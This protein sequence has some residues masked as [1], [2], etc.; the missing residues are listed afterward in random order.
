MSHRDPLLR[1]GLIGTGRIS[2]IYLRTCAKF[3]EVQVVACGSLNMDEARAKAAEH[4]IPRVATPDD[5]LADPDIDCILNLTIPAAHAEIS[6]AALAEGK[7][8]YSEKPF[9]TTVADGQRV[10]DLARTKGLKVGNAPDTF[11][12][13]RW[14][15]V[16]KLID[17]GEIGTPTGVSAFVGTHGVERHHPN[18][19]FYYQ[20][21]G[22][23]L[24]DLGPYYLTAMVFLLGPIAR[25]SGM[26]RRT[27]DKRQIENGP[28][29]GEWME[30]A[31]DTHSLSLLQFESGALGSMTMSFD[32]WD[33]ETPRLEIYGTEGTIC[34]PD[35][36]PVHGANDFHGPVWLRTRATSRWEF[37][38]RPTDRPAD[39]QEVAN[40][41]GFNE[42]SRGLGL[43]DLAYAV[44]DNRAPRASG[45]L[46]QHV[47][48][49]MTGIDA[50]PGQGG[51]VDILS[52]CTVPEPLPETFP[53]SEAP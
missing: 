48:E 22:G 31:V 13:G 12:G 1:V 44:R 10:L 53:A 38:P 4:S 16:R 26:S 39:W 35:P 8:V 36:D 15:T 37:Q 3:P 42:N 17:Q 19:D 29:N 41:H 52:R 11:L 34:I 45:E 9:A 2:D 50:A 7:H 6:L 49:V 25:V 40:T 32:V 28:R 33:S 18:P 5:I 14:Q 30:V 20:P 47:L 51:Y 23:P 27:F 24:F 21:G 46:A 43:L